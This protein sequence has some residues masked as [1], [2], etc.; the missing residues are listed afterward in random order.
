MSEEKTT[1]VILNKD[2]K[3][4]F[5]TLNFVEEN[6]RGLESTWMTGHEGCEFLTAGEIADDIINNR[7]GKSDLDSFREM[8]KEDLIMLHFSA[9]MWIRNKYGLWLEQNPHTTKPESMSDEEFAMADIHPDQYSFSVIEKV[10]SILND[11][12]KDSY[13]NS[14]KFI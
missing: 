10:H 12:P 3:A 1:D 11:T 7:I 8:K 2:G 14:M 9:G 5:V 4:Q 6:I 13:D